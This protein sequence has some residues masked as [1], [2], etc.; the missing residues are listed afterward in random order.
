MADAN[1]LD[2]LYL[3][4]PRGAG[5]AWLFRMATPAPL[6]GRPN[7]RTGR[8]YG[9]EIR[10]SL[11]GVRLL[12]EA[13][14]LR[15]LRLGAIRLE[16]AQAVGDANGGLEQAMEIAAGLRAIEDPETRDDVELALISR[17]EE[18][19]KR[20]GEKKAVRWYRTAVGAQT[21]F[22][23][24]CEQY[25]ADK[26]KSLSR[27]SLNNLDTAAK[28]F[29]EFAGEDVTLQEVDRRTV[30]RFATEFLPNKKGPKAP[31]GQGPATI[32]KKVSQLSQVWR[33]AQQRGL[34]PYSKET[35]W[36]GQAPSK[37]EIKARQKQRRIYEP[38]EIR[39]LLAAAPAGEALG[40]VLRVG[41]CRLRVTPR[42][43][44]ARPAVGRAD[45]GVSRLQRS[46]RSSGGATSG[47]P[48]ARIM[49]AFR[50]TALLNWARQNFSA[51][52]YSACEIADGF[53]S[54][55]GARL[56]R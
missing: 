48:A 49:Q 11:G 9:R 55:L 41:P 7:P 54:G 18:L 14:R 23:A 4:Q 22:K 31:D 50:S 39:K 43:P 36:D 40:D 15:D 27:S 51:K 45:V 37:K 46:S 20:V 25:K 3:F 5:T 24:A 52:R 34:L 28:E 33:W 2:T 8:A 13:R 47:V 32:G 42:E 6:V 29:R 21:P 44:E 19:E 12:T 35:P 30:A 16:E 56:G 17:A 38:E 53:T 26:G 1:M 10:E